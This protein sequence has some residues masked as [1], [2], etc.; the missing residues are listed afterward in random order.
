MG[1]PTFN[2]RASYPG[3]VRI[4]AMWQPPERIKH[5]LAPAA[6]PT[7][8]AAASARLFQP[9]ELGPRR[10]E[11]RTWVPA[12][13]PWR[14]TEDGF[15]TR[16]VIDWYRRF[17]QGRPGVLVVEATGIR[18]IPS[19]PLLRIGHDR[20]IP[21]LTELASAVHEASGGRTLLFIQLIDFL[22]IRR[23][24]ARD[25]YLAR[26]LVLE[27]RHREAL[28]QVTGDP[29]ARACGEVELRARLA[30]L[31]E[32]D[33]AYVLSQRE[34]EDLERG[35]RERVTDVQ[36]PHVAELPRVLPPLFADAA[37]RAIAAGFDGVE[38]HFA[39]A[40]TMASF[41]SALNTRDDGYGGPR[42]QRVRLPR[43]VI[44]AVRARVAG[45][46]VVG[47]R[48]LGDDV[49]EGGNR[50]DDAA[51]FGVELARAGLDFLSISKGGKFEDAKQPK[52][53][54]A[55]YPYTGRSG[56]ECMPTIYSDARG[57]F[58]RNVEL[59]ARIRAAVH[60]A[61]FATPVVTAGGIC[62]FAQA[63]G[64][65]ARG[66]ADFV[67]SAR[68]TL[69]DPDWFDKIREGRGAEI[70]RCEFTNYCEALD[71]Q[72][73][74]VTCKLWDRDALD[75]PDVTLAADGKRRLLAPRWRR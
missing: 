63:E 21:G 36:L 40:Y 48:Y 62:D 45:R 15:V 74:Q 60:G 44:A 18:D 17:A 69:A 47:C 58:A 67:A 3:V 6:W 75:E 41:L 61:G 43:E 24:P 51:W 49:V 66:D 68:Q 9:G 34:L 5:E 39:H 54:W 8:D 28:A 46:G 35:Y 53:G 71:Q 26:F 25:K 33:L 23:R 31:N 72:H 30:A 56:Y 38:L 20:F 65:L 2:T 73:K 22:S 16:D 19:G 12:M 29:A 7:S 11:T 50:V 37:G 59:A 64:I 27:P 13:V 32:T 14:A 10:A 57:P 55:A 4:R 1:S 52:V 42:E 70:R